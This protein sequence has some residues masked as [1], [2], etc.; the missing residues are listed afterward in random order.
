MQQN[1]GKEGKW[2]LS[3]LSLLPCCKGICSKHFSYDGISTGYLLCGRHLSNFVWINS[4]NHT[5]SPWGR[6]CHESPETSCNCAP[7]RSNIESLGPSVC[8]YNRELNMSSAWKKYLST[9]P[10]Q[11]WIMRWQAEVF[12]LHT[13]H[14]DPVFPLESHAHSRWALHVCD[15]VDEIL[16]DSRIRVTL[17]TH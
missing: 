16:G 11:M 1:W 8:I 7:W 6:D 2:F 10:W 14:W 15:G 3:Y 12:W 9:T 13:L 5:T 4:C 17:A